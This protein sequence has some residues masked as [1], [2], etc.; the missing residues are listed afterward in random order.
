MKAAI[1]EEVNKLVLRDV[2]TPGIDPDYGMLVKVKACAVCG[3]DIRIF[4]H[5]NPRIKTPHIIGHEIAGEVIEVGRRVT[6]F[7]I[8]DRVAI[9]ADV[10]CGKCDYCRE[11]HG[12][13]CKVN[14]AI[15]YQFPG[16]FAEFIPL[17]QLT[18]QL[19]PVHKIPEGVS[20]E[21]A[22]LAEPLA[23]CINGLE[24]T[25]VHLGD[26]VVIIGAGP[27]GCMLTQLS[28]HMSASKIILAQRS[29]SRLEQA[30]RFEADVYISTLE[31][32]LVE[33]VMSETQG[34]GAHL[35]IVA[36]ASLD[37]QR[38]ALDLVRPGGMVNFFGGLPANSP[39]LE[40]LSN[41]IHYRECLV[42][43]SHGSVPRQ[44]RLALELM[45]SG[46]VDMEG[47]ITNYFTLEEINKAF[48]VAEG[49]QGLKVI[50]K[51]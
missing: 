16:G 3:S 22:A 39:P 8:G 21:A 1:F 42:T 50:V 31:E 30:R 36:C 11:G 19:G 34:Q 4:H 13:R 43:G 9:G 40:V 27:V 51:P 37:A 48:S 2:P 12:N 26:T 46:R 38:Q 45:R 14:Y 6:G 5:G 41:H 10:P 18:I 35:V 29:K 24:L 7:K 15:G 28:R 33:R 47:L 44:H 17:N 23:C 20:Y 49:K 25:P 32:D